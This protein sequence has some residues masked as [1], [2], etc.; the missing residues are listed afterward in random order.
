MYQIQAA[1][2]ELSSSCNLKCRHCYNNSGVGSVNSI[3]QTNLIR[4]V[5]EL[6]KLGCKNI[7][8]S[9]GEPLTYG[10]IIEIIEYISE[11]TDVRISIVT[12]AT[13]ISG[14]FLNQVSQNLSR[15][16]IV[17]QVSLDGITADQHEYLRG[18]GTFEPMMQGLSILERH[19][20]LY[21]F[22]VVIRKKNYRSWQSII[23]Y[24]ISKKH[25]NI[26]FTFIQSKGRAKN[27]S[28]IFDKKTYFDILSELNQLRNEYRANLLCKAEIHNTS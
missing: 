20:F 16:R 25:R 2:I 8:L 17:F 24:A 19:A 14:D 5:D 28:L 9:G 11:Y 10:T 21:Y 15:G 3:D 26:D 1:Y 27:D 7:S 6:A 13:L 22:H 4:I 12:N 23:E 18:A